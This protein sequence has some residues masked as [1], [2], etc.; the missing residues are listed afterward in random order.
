MYTSHPLQL[1]SLVLNSLDNTNMIFHKDF[2]YYVALHIYDH[3]IYNQFFMN[4]F[5]ILFMCEDFSSII[6]KFLAYEV[7]R[8]LKY[9]SSLLR[10]PAFTFKKSNL[11]V[12]CDFHL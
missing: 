1:K 12:Q 9:F 10:T 5:L 3:K 11:L 4:S 8:S 2:F 7:R 6:A